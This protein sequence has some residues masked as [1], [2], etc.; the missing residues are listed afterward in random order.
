M[1]SQKL[2][3]TDAAGVYAWKELA[4]CYPLYWESGEPV[5]DD[6]KAALIDVL[7]FEYA[8]DV[9]FAEWENA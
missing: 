9:A 2:L 1:E 4:E 3:I 8:L 7:P 6:V 5:G